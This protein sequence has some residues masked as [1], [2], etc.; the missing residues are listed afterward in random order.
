M[1]ALLLGTQ[2]RLAG[3]AGMFQTVAGGALRRFVLGVDLARQG[4]KIVCWSNNRGWVD[5]VLHLLRLHSSAVPS[6]AFHHQVS[7][8]RT[9]TRWPSRIPAPEFRS[10]LA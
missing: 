9:S 7:H 2:E 3:A 10:R 4:N 1:L 6:G 8:Q 5:H